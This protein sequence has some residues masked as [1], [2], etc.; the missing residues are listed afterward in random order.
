LTQNVRVLFFFKTLAEIDPDTEKKG[1]RK[2]TGSFLH[3]R[4]IVDYEQTILLMNIWK[5]NFNSRWG[6]ST[7]PI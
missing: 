3:L 7:E 6:I 4:E 2:S 1:Q 5:Q